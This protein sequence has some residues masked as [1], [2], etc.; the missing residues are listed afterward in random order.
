MIEVRTHSGPPRSCPRCGREGLVTLDVPN[1]ITNVREEE[2]TGSIPITLCATCDHDTPG[3]GPLITFLTV[4]ERITPAN[5]EEFA[6]YAH[7]WVDQIVV[8]I[9][10]ER[11]CEDEEAYRRGEFD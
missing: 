6:A 10:P 2:V 8:H 9:D 4:H 3:A 7:R 1:S 5:A 11:L